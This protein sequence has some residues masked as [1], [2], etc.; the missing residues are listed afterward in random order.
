MANFPGRRLYP[1]AGKYAMSPARDD[2]PL[3]KVPPTSLPRGGTT[4]DYNVKLRG[5]GVRQDKI[6]GL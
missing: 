5:Q 3:T 6:P 4:A 1:N 2:G